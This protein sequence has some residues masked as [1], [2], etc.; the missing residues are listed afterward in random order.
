MKET[1][2]EETAGKKEEE[3]RRVGRK[4]D[5]IKEQKKMKR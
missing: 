3:G 1:P 5:R 4:P 2:G